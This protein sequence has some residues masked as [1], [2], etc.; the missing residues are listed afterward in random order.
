MSFQLFIMAFIVV[1]RQISRFATRGA[2]K[3][4]GAGAPKVKLGGRGGGG[5]TIK[6]VV[7]SYC[8]RASQKI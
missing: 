5:Y 8:Q 7:N 3:S 6:D 4:I 2:Q 1:K